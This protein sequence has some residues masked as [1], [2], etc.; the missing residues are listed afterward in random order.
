MLNKN[1]YRQYHICSV[2]ITW[3]WCDENIAI[4]WFTFVK[5]YKFCKSID[6]KLIS[7]KKV[8]TEQANSVEL[9]SAIF[10]NI[11]PKAVVMVWFGLAFCEITLFFFFSFGQHRLSTIMSEAFYFVALIFWRE[12]KI[13]WI[14]GCF[15]FSKTM[16][17]FLNLCFPPPHTL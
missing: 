10:W 15:D 11:S 16:F 5:G 9:F 2:F 4:S 12:A 17:I 1:I 8:R 14:R 7:F 3:H 6:E 13:I